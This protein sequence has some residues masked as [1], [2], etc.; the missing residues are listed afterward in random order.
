MATII[1]SNI[2]TL[3]TALILAYFTSGAVRGFA[4]TLIIGTISSMFTAI[5]VTRSFVD[6]FYDLKIIKGIQS[7]KLVRR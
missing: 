2:T 4:V 7:F 5:F 1:D 6:L 3:I